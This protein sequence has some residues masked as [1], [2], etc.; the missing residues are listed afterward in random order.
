LFV[1][2]HTGAYRHFEVPLERAYQVYARAARRVS[3]LART[4]KG[5][6]MSTAAGK[7]EILGITEVNGSKVFVLR[8]IQS[9]DPENS[10]QPFFAKY[11]P[12]A[13]WFDQL[14]LT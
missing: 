2:R 12:E 13:T 14:T 6:V 10:F 1:E 4:A 5:P 11:D 9:R 8:F 3:G 7:V